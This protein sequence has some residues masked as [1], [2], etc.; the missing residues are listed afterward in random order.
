M[1][2]EIRM[3]SKE[4]IPTSFRIFLSSIWCFGVPL[5]C[6]T[7]SLVPDILLLVRSQSVSV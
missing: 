1:G 5:Y 3:L 6:S 2:L 7:R 4:T